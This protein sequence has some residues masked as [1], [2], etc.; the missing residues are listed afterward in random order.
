LAADWTIV[1]RVDKRVK[2]S[3]RRSRTNTYEHFVSDG[4]PALKIIDVGGT[5]IL[6]RT[7]VCGL[8]CPQR[9]CEHHEG[10]RESKFHS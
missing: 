7:D 6:L 1:D 8:Q 10:D 5:G 3:E 2:R 4:R 9:R